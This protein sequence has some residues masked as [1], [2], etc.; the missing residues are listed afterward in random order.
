MKKLGMTIVDY[1]PF[2]IKFNSFYWI[3]AKSKQKSVIRFTGEVS[4]A[5]SMVMEAKIEPL[6]KAAD[7]TT[8]VGTENSDHPEF[9]IGSYKKVMSS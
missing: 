3:F 4:R 9:Q 6:K 5:S 1:F 7:V 8:L 2:K